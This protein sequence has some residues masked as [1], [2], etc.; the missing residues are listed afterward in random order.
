[1]KKIKVPAMVVSAHVLICLFLSCDWPFLE[2]MYMGFG[3]TFFILW[4]LTVPLITACIAMI[5]TLVKMKKKEAKEVDFLAAIAGAL[6]FITYICS[7]F[8]LLK[9]TALHVGYVLLLVGTVLTWSCWICMAIKKR[10][11]DHCKT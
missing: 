3:L 11:N 9:G 7:A 6:V 10:F 2:G 5:S 4:G 1:M 8:G